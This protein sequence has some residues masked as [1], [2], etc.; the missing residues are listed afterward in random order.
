MESDVFEFR[1]V[2]SDKPPTRRG[3]L[4]VISS[5]YDPLGFAALFTLPA[6]KILQ[7]LN[8][9]RIGWD[10]TVPDKHQRRWAKWL[11]ELPLLEQLK[12]NRCLQPDKFGTVTSQ[13]VHV[14][15]DASSIGYSAVAYLRL[16]DDSNRIHCTFLMLQGGVWRQAWPSG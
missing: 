13:Q 14:F 2:V 11:S 10:D 8:R 9:E 16:Q 3:I 5:V 1:I 12:V 15:S 6:K 4:S 7:D